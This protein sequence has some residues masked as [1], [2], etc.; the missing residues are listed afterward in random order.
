M[1]TAE[2]QL[3]FHMGTSLRVR[4]TR[5]NIMDMAVLIQYYAGMPAA[6]NGAIAAKTVF[7][8]TETPPAEVD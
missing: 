6:Y 1:D 8:A 3:R 4:L 2:P 5:A 7:E